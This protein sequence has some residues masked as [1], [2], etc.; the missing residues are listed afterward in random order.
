MVILSCSK[1]RILEEL[2]YADFGHQDDQGFDSRENALTWSTRNLTSMKLLGVQVVKD[3]FFESLVGKTLP[4]HSKK[5]NPI[6]KLQIR[7]ASR[8]T[9]TN[10]SLLQS[11][12]SHSHTYT[13]QSLLFFSALPPSAHHYSATSGPPLDVAVVTP[14]AA[15]PPP[16]IIGLSWVSGSSSSSHRLIRLRHRVASTI[17]IRVCCSSSSSVSLPPVTTIRFVSVVN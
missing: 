16:S 15:P 3:R 7:S 10:P 14:A 13:E 2:H 17:L 8:V 4:I 6:R 9:F 11:S 12:P 1:I 5:S